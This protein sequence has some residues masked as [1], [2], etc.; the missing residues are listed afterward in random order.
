MSSVQSSI[1]NT[2]D[3]PSALSQSRWSMHLFCRSWR[4]FQM[5]SLSLLM[6]K[7]F[8]PLTKQEANAVARG[9]G[10]P[11]TTDFSA[12]RSDDRDGPQADIAVL[13]ESPIQTKDGSQPLSYSFIEI[14]L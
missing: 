12:Y 10:Y 4:W 6:V 5:T 13:R 9:D 1:K 14:T 2:A 7:N 3:S 8:K 11:P